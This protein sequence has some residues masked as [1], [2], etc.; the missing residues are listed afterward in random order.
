M[1]ELDCARL[2]QS[3]NKNSVRFI[4]IGGMNYFLRYRP[5]TTQDIDIW[6]EPTVENTARCE[7]ALNEIDAEWGKGDEDLGPTRLKPVGWLR[8]QAVYCLLTKCGF[9]DIFRSVV[10]LANFED[11][12]DRAEIATMADGIVFHSLCARVMIDCQL[13]LPE[14]S[15]KQDRINHLKGLLGE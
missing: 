5:V 1:N 8:S 7:S 6:I 14:T 4:L 11:S 12:W 9:V 15:R 2:L 3:L 13:A 10:G